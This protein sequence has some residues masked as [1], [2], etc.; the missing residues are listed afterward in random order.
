MRIIS[1]N[2][3]P[4]SGMNSLKLQQKTTPAFS[5]RP[6]VRPLLAGNWKM[7]I[8]PS[9]TKGFFQQFLAL[10]NPMLKTWSAKESKV[11][12]PE[13]LICP[14][15]LGIPAAQKAVGKSKAVQIGAQNCHFEPNGAYTGEV[16]PAMLKAQGINTVIIGHSERR[17]MFNETNV[18]V[19]QKVHAALNE[20][21]KPIVCCGETLE[22][23]NDGVTDL[24]ISM[25]ILTALRGVKKD[26][27]KNVVI[28]YEPIWAIG[29]GKTCESAEANRVCGVIRDVVGE[30]YDKTTAHNTR[31]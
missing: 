24:H 9:E 20:G 10:V 19:N 28:A 4:Q 17:Q 30:K 27:M 26:Q 7:N 6:G 18:S 5:A 22:Q 11:M 29:N 15:N 31:I 2:Y 12:K 21:M 25:Q 13:I 8:L 23:R 16:S 1:Q 14:T 3:M